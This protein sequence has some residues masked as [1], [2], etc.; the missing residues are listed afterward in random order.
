M[1]IEKAIELLKAGRYNE[2]EY[3]EAKN[4]AV[5]ALEHQMKNERVIADKD[6]N[7]RQDKKMAAEGET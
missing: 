2:L 4:M 7:L 5:E 3:L 6:C 1:T